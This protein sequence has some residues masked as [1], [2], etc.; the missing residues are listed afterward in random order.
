MKT[1]QAW[2]IV[3]RLRSVSAEEKLSLSFE[4]KAA[5][6]LRTIETR[7]RRYYA[8]W[9]RA[10]PKGSMMF[11]FYRHKSADYYLMQDLFEDEDGKE[12]GQS[13]HIWHRAPKKATEERL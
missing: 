9:M 7:T 1:R 8:S 3:R 6:A 10:Y 2:K 13:Y 4:K 11:N 5:K 12:L